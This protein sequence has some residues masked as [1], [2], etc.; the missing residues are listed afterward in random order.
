M[1]R[2]WVAIAVVAVPAVRYLVIGIERVRPPLEAGR[3]AGA[4]RCAAVIAVAERAGG[5]AAGL[6]RQLAAVQ[7]RVCALPVVVGIA[8]R[9]TVACR[10]AAVDRSGDGQ[11]V[12]HAVVA[13]RGGNVEGIKQN[14]TIIP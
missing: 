6:L 11:A 7:G 10:C 1:K 14:Q 12:P 9:A 8:R 5:A 13:A 4:A 3:I 2:L